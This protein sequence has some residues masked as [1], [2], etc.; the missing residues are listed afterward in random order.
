MGAEISSAWWSPG[1]Q[2]HSVVGRLN[3]VAEVRE[4]PPREEP[5]EHSGVLGSQIC[6]GAHTFISWM[7]FGV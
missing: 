7:Q 1:R 6:P 5:R 4:K 3:G 2:R